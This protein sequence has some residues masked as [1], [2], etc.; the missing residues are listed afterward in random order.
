VGVYEDND[1]DLRCLLGSEETM[2]QARYRPD[3]IWLASPPGEAPVCPMCRSDLALDPTRDRPW[4]GRLMVLCETCMAP[5]ELAP[6]AD[7]DYWIAAEHYGS[8]EQ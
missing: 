8:E 3:T 7:G 4:H 1:G 2:A 6:S 5:V